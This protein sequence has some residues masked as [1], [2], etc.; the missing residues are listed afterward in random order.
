M[1]DKSLS[2]N[3]IKIKVKEGKDKM[4]GKEKDNQKII[5]EKDNQ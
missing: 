3:S 5:N 4:R 1:I 2:K